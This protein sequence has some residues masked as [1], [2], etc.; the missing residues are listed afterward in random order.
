MKKQT[1]IEG[2]LI[3]AVVGLVS[4]FLGLF[5]RW[6]LV[7]MMG[8]EGLGYYQMVFPLYSFFIA[9]A[10]GIPIAMS[11]LVSENNNLGKEGDNFKLM[12]ISVMLLM[13][14]ALS[15]TFILGFYGEKIVDLFNWDKKAYYSIIAISVAPLFISVVNPIRG[16]F[17][18]YKNMNET[19]VSQFVEQIGRVIFGVG[20]AYILLPKGIEYGA[21]GATFGATAGGGLAAIYLIFRYFKL[22]PRNISRSK[23]RYSTLTKKL[24]FASIPIAIGAAVVSIMGIIDAILV[25]QKLLKAG[26]SGQEATVL[27]SQLTGKAT[28]LIHIPMTLSVA[29]GSALVPAISASNAAKDNYEMSKNI[30]TAMKFVFVISLPCFMGMFFMA[31]P[32]MSTI[33]PG[34]D[35]GADILRWLSISIPFLVLTQI[36][37]SILQGIG[38]MTLPVI[39]MLVGS[40]AK[41]ILTMVLVPMPQFNIQGAV[42]STITSYVI[43]G[44]LNVI[45]IKIN[46]KYKSDLKETLWKPLMASIGMIIVTM[47]SFL[48]LI[49]VWPKQSL[50]CIISICIGGIVYLLLI[51]LLKVFDYK[52]LKGR[53]MGKINNRKIS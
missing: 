29:I 53:A 16:F 1:F 8:D 15:V 48:L 33:F 13:F 39:N 36:T 27:F 50:M 30:S 41:L 44:L 21:A 46:I 18:G 28:A 10:G 40:V 52:Y 47:S 2:G 22:K 37:T 6:P 5:F 20:L 7:M 35:G 49:K 4:K 11:K 23:T 43:I 24:I 42:I 32:I 45:C 26:F 51:M 12:K 19:A 38:K 31:E 25:P 14:L 3:L 9:I 17:Q 34:R